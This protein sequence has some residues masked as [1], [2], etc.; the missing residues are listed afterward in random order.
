MSGSMSW[1]VAKAIGT[2]PAFIGGLIV[3]E[4]LALAVMSCGIGLPI[5]F[6]LMTYFAANGLPLGGTMEFSGVVLPGRLHPELVMVS[7]CSI[8]A[9]CHFVNRRCRDLSS[10][11]CRS[12]R[13]RTVLTKSLVGGAMSIV[14]ETQNLRRCYGSWRHACGRGQRH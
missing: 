12:D 2:R 9:V 7:I 1:R 4:A 5:A 10:A 11:F 13:A 8:P 14:I 6:C 3:L